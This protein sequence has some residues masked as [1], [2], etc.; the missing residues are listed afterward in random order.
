MRDSQAPHE[1]V[2]SSP[3]GSRLKRP[4]EGPSAGICH[5]S[6]SFMPAGDGDSE[7]LGNPYPAGNPQFAGSWVEV[8]STP[9]GLHE[10]IGRD[11]RLLHDD[12]STT[13]GNT[14]GHQE[15]LLL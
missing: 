8:G 5:F 12:S 4:I 9:G 10:N 1:A 6:R 7:A 13:H 3:V 11:E 2:V 15:A 14:L